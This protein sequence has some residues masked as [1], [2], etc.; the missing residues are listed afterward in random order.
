MVSRHC[1][2][3]PA[4]P[5]VPVLTFIIGLVLTI[6]SILGGYLALGGHLYVLWQPFE[7]IIILGSAIGSFFVANPMKIV[8]DTGAGIMEAIKESTPKPQE[9]LDLLSLL[10][11]LMKELRSK[12]RTEMET[13][14][15]NPEESSIFKGYP[16][17]LKN[18]Q[19]L[20]FICDYARL[21]VIGNARSHEIEALMEEEI[22]TIGHDKLKVYHAM[23]GIS[24]GLPA[25]GIVAAVLGVIHAMGALNESPEVLGHLIGAAL[26]GTFAGIFFSYG[27]FGPLATKIK[28]V[29]EKK[30]R[31]YVIIKQTL[32]AYMNGAMPQVALE[33]GRKTISAY[34][35]P[36]INQ[37][38][39]ETMNH[40]TV[41]RAA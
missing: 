8:K 18:Q 1:F 41:E 2:V 17:I 15:D 10:Y 21:I 24:D 31:L 22:E 19:L 32:I 39:E 13:H 35:R 38:E 7:F 11:G 37:V 14:V 40:G 12:S 29:R 3:C 4:E 16:A 33:H 25:L 23:L 9:Y 6:T 30:V 34:E 28:S 5:G 27:F 26:V 20:N 36:T